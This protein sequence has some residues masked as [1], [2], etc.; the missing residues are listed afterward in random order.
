MATDMDMIMN[1][2]NFLKCFLS[3]ITCVVITRHRKIPM[4]HNYTKV[5]ALTKQCLLWLK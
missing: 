4:L 5:K 2:V 1:M 3:L